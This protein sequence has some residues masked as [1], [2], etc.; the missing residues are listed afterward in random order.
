MGHIILNIDVKLCTF[1]NRFNSDA[2]ERMND[3]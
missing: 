3:T 2:T 1:A